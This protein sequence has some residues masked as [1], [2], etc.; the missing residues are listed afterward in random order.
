MIIEALG[1]WLIVSLV[2]GI[3][4]GTMIDRMGK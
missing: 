4:V 1:A 2:I 3:V